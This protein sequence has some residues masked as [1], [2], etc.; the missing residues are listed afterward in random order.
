MQKDIVNGLLL[1][2]ASLFENHLF[3]LICNLNQNYLN[4]TS[5]VNEGLNT[6]IGQNIPRD[7]PIRYQTLTHFKEI[8]K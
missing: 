2:Q 1:S 3:Y 6:D 8:S 5:T 7:L 4:S